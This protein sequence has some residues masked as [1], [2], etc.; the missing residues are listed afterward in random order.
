MLINFGKGNES[1]YPCS[2]GTIYTASGYRFTVSFN[3]FE[4]FGDS[5]G[6]GHWEI[7]TMA[8]GQSGQEATACYVHNNYNTVLYTSDMAAS[9][10]STF[11]YMTTNYGTLEEAETIGN[12]IVTNLVGGKQYPDIYEYYDWHATGATPNEIAIDGNG[13]G[14]GGLTWGCPGP[15]KGQAIYG[16]AGAEAADR[17]GLQS[18][19]AGNSA[20]AGG[21]T[22]GDGSG[23][24]A[25]G[26][27]ASLLPGVL[28]PANYPTSKV[29][30]SLFNNRVTSEAASEAGHGTILNG[31]FGYG[32]MFWTG[33]F[34]DGGATGSSNTNA[35]ALYW[36]AEP[37]TSGG[38]YQLGG[39]GGCAVPVT[40]SENS[41][42]RSGGP[43]ANINALTGSTG[44]C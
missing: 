9:G 3:Y 26:S 37:S 16:G 38:G 41:E 43:Y 2:N 21:C 30:N 12:T 15:T 11:F 14:C 25:S 18:Y 28:W 24:C 32:A 44:G 23:I 1:S 13:S 31:L 4:D 39:G 27:S 17:P 34:I 19:D 36:D 7:T 10:T 6:A 42:L 5:F 33:N 40:I 35:T 22:N 8:L 29:A 20:W